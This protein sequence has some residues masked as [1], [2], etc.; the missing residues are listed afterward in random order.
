MT[1]TRVVAF[2]WL[3]S[4]VAL[5]DAIT[6]TVVDVPTRGVTV[7]VAYV[8]P[9]APVANFIGYIGGNGVAGIGLGFLG[10]PLSFAYASR[11]IAVAYVDAP[12]DHPG[13]LNK[14]F[15]QS[16]EH[17]ADALAVI[18]FVR[19]QADVPIWLGGIS[20]G[21]VS[22]TYFAL[23]LPAELPFG[24]V[25]A[26]SKTVDGDLAASVFTMDLES[27][28]RPTL[29]LAHQEDPCPVTPPANAPLLY[30]RLTSAP[31]KELIFMTGGIGTPADGCNT[32]H[33]LFE[34]QDD[35]VAATTTAFIKKYNGLLAGAASDANYQGL[36]WAA[37][38]TESFWGINFAHSGDRVFATWYTYDTTGKAWWLSM[39]AG[40]TTPNS[41]EYTG[42]INVDVGP[43]F[44]NFVG[45]GMPTKVGT[46]TLTFSDANHGT[47]HYDLNAGTGGAPGPVSQDKMIERYNLGTGSQP[48]C[49]FS[50]TANLALATNYQDLWWKA[51]Q[52]EQGWGINF[53]HQGDSVFATWYTYD[54]GGA[55]LWLSVLTQRQGTTNVYKGDL[56]RISGPRFDNYKASDVVQPIPTVGTATL[57]FADGNSA[58]FDYVTDGSGG[59]PAVHQNK[60]IVRFPFGPGGTVC[61]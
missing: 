30:A 28:R 49:T 60:T 57:T 34:G 54:S 43:P 35:E 48:T 27:I 37:G 9:D 61:Q 40:R 18:N 5:A 8:K 59:L 53:A 55:P 23:N 15:R 36:W 46:G 31:A 2:W 11:G 58:M 13:G 56:L 4:T 1:I 24:V 22:V 10:D 19:Q 51:D 16:P 52:T 7:R 33:H 3:A 17:A 20:N 42:D 21:T 38:G 41:N 25:L 50:A 47:F 6:V 12:S 29:V 39:L 26:S 32:G 45:S 14:Q 44:N